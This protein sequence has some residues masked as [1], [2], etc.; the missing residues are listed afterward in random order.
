VKYCKFIKDIYFE[1]ELVWESGKEYLVTYENESTYF[2]GNPIKEGI[3][4]KDE[5]DIYV[6]VEGGDKP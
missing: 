1:K 6:V 5:N 4:K 3:S 2:F